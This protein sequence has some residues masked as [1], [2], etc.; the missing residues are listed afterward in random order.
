M[1][2]TDEQIRELCEKATAGPWSDYHDTFE[3]AVYTKLED[4]CKGTIISRMFGLYEANTSNDAQFIAAARELVPQL[5]ERAQR[6]EAQLVEQAELLSAAI[7]GQETLQRALAEA[8]KWVAVS[9]GLPK[10]RQ[11]VL[12]FYTNDCGARRIEIACYTPPRTVRAE[13]FLSDD[14]YGEGYDEYDEEN[15]CFWVVEGWWEDSL[16]AEINWKIISP[17]THWMPLP[18]TPKEG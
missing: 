6:A 8:R 14:Y 2:L 11:R 7:T 18:E 9:E 13:D 15:D 16:E 12:A 5:L 10:A 1:T 3:P 17:V 4:G